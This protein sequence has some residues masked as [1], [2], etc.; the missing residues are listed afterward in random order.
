MV[1]TELLVQWTAVSL[2]RFDGREDHMWA[3]MVGI[4]MLPAHP[5][6]D[7]GSTNIARAVKCTAAVAA[8]VATGVC[9][10]NGIGITQ[11]VHGV[12]WTPATLATVNHILCGVFSCILLM[13]SVL[14]DNLSSVFG[15]LLR[16]RQELFAK[17]I[18]SSVI[19]FIF[20]G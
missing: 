6:L 18:S 8:I 3:C 20:D 11:D 9:R 13:G 17:V 4:A 12:D 10:M 19:V 2:A 5:N 1:Q 15:S 7:V 16:A 14:A